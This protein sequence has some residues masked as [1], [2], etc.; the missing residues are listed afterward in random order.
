MIDVSAEGVDIGCNEDPARI[1]T[2]FGLYFSHT[3]SN[4]FEVDDILGR[5]FRYIMTVLKKRR[6][7][8]RIFCW[9]GGGL[10][11]FAV[12]SWSM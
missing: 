9:N 6:V 7:F 11:I 10:R 2:S 3:S 5:I 4:I 1:A 8:W 12:N